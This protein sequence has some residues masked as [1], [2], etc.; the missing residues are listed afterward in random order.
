MNDMLVR[1]ER[2]LALLNLGIADALACGAITHQ[3]AEV[4]LYSPGSMRFCRENGIVGDLPKA[5]WLGCQLESSLRL[6][7]EENWSKLI[8]ELRNLSIQVLGKHASSSTQLDPWWSGL[9]VKE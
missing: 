6:L 9:P 3:E 4:L 5:I 1:A 2:L 8:A 7:G